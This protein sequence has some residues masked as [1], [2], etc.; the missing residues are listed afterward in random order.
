M[1]YAVTLPLDD[2]AAAEVQRMW[3]ALAEQAS[4]DDVIRLGYVPHITLAV[5]PNTASAAEVEE[6]AFGVADEWTPLLIVLVG[7]G[8]FPGSPPVIWAAPV[9]TADLLTRH[10]E[11]YSAL[12]RFGVHAHYEPGFWVPHVTLS[13]EGATSAARAIEAADSA[14]C[15]PINAMLERVELVRFRPVE[16]LRRQAL[17][18]GP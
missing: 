15:G 11:L 18:R 14:W 6:A 3:R 1:P 2:A 16:V 7:L 5:L 10:A 8:V 12:A 9:V 4:A 13:K 17:H